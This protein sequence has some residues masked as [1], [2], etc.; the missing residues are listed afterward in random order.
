MDD[1]KYDGYRS[2]KGM[3]IRLMEHLGKRL[4]L[5]LYVL[6]W[7]LIIG[8]VTACY[9]NFVNWVIGLVWHSYLQGDNPLGRWYPFLV[10]GLSGLAIGLL[11]HYWGNYPLTIEQVLTQ[12]R[13]HGSIDYHQWWKSFGL[14]VMVLGLGG[15]VGPEASTAVLTS[16]MI[17]WLGDRL[18]WATVNY[19]SEHPWQLWTAR[20][21]SAQLAP[22]PRF[23]QLFTSRWQQKM[24]VTAL[25]VVGI[26]G[27]GIVF[28]FFSE[29]GVFGIHH[30]V[31]NWAVANLWTWAPALIVGMILGWFFVCL[32]KWFVR[33]INSRFSAV[34]NTNF[35]PSTGD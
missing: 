1:K 22:A 20:M 10:C 26:V 6:F 28:K 4:N 31:I 14:G 9:L 15:S 24:I 12:A 16:S 19:E 8:I 35:W 18:R 29:E 5:L 27:A 21:K 32:E 7:S 2:V 11:N 3:R 34:P 30:H 17:N 33:I 23:G 25:I 13:L